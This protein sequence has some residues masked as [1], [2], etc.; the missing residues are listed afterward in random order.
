MRIHL[1]A[2]AVLTLAALAQPIAGVA[3]KFQEPSK[4]ELQMTSDPKAPGGAAVYL[5][6][7][8]KMDNETHIVMEYARIKILTEKGKESATVLVPYVAFYEGAPTIEGRTIHADGTVVPLQGKASDLLVSKTGDV[9]AKQAVFNMP[10]VEVGSILEYRW[11]LPMTGSH[12]IGNYSSSYGWEIPY[13]EV[14]RSIYIHRAHFFYNPISESEK[15]T[16]FGPRAVAAFTN[17][18]EVSVLAFAQRLPPGFQVV[19]SQAADYT[20]DIHDVPALPQES[21]APPKSALRYDVRFYFTRTTNPEQ[22]WSQETARWSKELDSFAAPTGAVR[23]AVDQTVAGAAAPEARARK[24]YDAVQAMDNTDFTRKK[25]ESERERLHLKAEIKK[26]D[27]VLKERSGSGNELAALYL[28]MLRAAGVKAD[29]IKV[30]DRREEVFDR[31]YLTLDQLDDLLVVLHL[32][33]K[34]VY[35]DPGQKLCPF[36]QLHWSHALVGGIQQGSPVPIVT[37]ANLAKDA[38]TA[39]AADLHVDA[40][41]QIDGTVQWVM[42]GPDALHWRQLNLTADRSE[43]E[44]QLKEGLHRLLSGLNA[45]ISGIKGLDTAEGFLQATVKVSGS[46]GTVTGKRLFLPAFLFSGAASTQFVSEEK[47]EA[48]VDLHYAEQVIDDVVYRLPAGYS[49]ESAPQPAELPWPGH[50]ALV[51]KTQPGQGT[52]DIKHIFARGFVL[53][54]P[55]EYPALRDYYQKVAATDQQQL[56]LTAAAGAAG[57]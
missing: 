43:V 3:Q 41:G 21:H 55:K 57:N 22:F 17:G 37:P 52:I 33:G 11:T 40:S 23:V 20:L 50:A 46:L 44:K 42:N 39:R 32:D 31:N 28:A 51:V 36:G 9:K 15:S 56:V 34:E 30:A 29:G 47:R 49:V 2:G 16:Y 6:L 10:S 24:L 12:D 8:D 7:E 48:P 45:E 53:L 27:E 1:L 25:S 5:Y 19:R 4:E 13:W 26:A 35:T 14:Q 54:D 18:Y 38:I